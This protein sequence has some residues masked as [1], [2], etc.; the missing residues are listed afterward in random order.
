MAAH[1][2]RENFEK[3]PRQTYAFHKYGLPSDVPPDGEQSGDADSD[4]ELDPHGNRWQPGLLLQLAKLQSLLKP[5]ADFKEVV[6]LG[7]PIFGCV[8]RWIDVAVPVDPKA[9]AHQA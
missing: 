2:I 7:G 8:C 9:C 1:A 5:C 3:M 6:K 4:D